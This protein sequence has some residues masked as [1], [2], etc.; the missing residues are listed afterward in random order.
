VLVTVVIL[1]VSL[2]FILRSFSRALN[3]AKYSRD[4][5]LASCLVKNKMWEIEIAHKNKIEFS[6]SG[7][8][9]QGGVTFRWQYDVSDTDVRTIKK[10]NFKLF[11]EGDSKS[12]GFF[13]EFSTYLPPAG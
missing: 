3:S 13:E 7:A 8:Q 4:I 10:L 1:S 5:I 12:N 6:P 11:P 2:V 9:E